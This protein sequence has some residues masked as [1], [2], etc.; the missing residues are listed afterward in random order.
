MVERRTVF[1]FAG[2]ASL[3]V[4]VVVV[5]DSSIEKSI[6]K[7]Q[8][9]KLI[10]YS[11]FASESIPCLRREEIAESFD[12]VSE[13][14][15][16][17]RKSI[18]QAIAKNQGSPPYRIL[19]FNDTTILE[20]QD[21]D[22]CVPLSSIA[23]ANKKLYIKLEELKNLMASKETFSG[24]SPTKEET[25]QPSYK[26]VFHDFLAERSPT[27]EEV[28]HR[29]TFSITE[30][31]PPAYAG[32]DRPHYAV[33]GLST[34]TAGEEGKITV[35]T[36]G[37]VRP[38]ASDE[39][40]RVLFYGI[41]AFSPRAWHVDGDGR[42]TARFTPLDPGLYR[43]HVESIRAAATA[44]GPP[45]ARP[46]EGSPFSLLVRPAGSDGRSDEQVAATLRRAARRGAPPPSPAHPS[47]LPPPRW[48]TLQRPSRH[49]PGSGLRLRPRQ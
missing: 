43:V 30:Q 20:A 31:E 15:Q 28:E 41:A 6:L 7:S 5:I 23:E 36:R 18:G 46:V 40:I 1:L 32:D 19:S 16:E 27:P 10:V 26:D 21:S 25:E 22:P 4:F 39:L 45:V 49:P 29:A 42:W 24:E 38:G 3:F 13:E 44:A 14:L 11:P 33:T 48:P 8:I 2:L 47:R 35:D 9:G 37:A 17:L 12:S 34:L